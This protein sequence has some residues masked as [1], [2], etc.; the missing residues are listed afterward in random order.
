MLD[1]NKVIK[2]FKEE[3]DP[4]N[5]WQQ[6]LRTAFNA[7]RYIGEEY[8]YMKDNSCFGE[9]FLISLSDFSITTADNNDAQD[10]VKS[11]KALVVERGTIMQ[12]NKH[13]YRANQTSVTYL[14]RS[15]ITFLTGCSGHLE[16]D[17]VQSR[18]SQTIV[19][20]HHIKQIGESGFVKI[21]IFRQTKLQV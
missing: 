6:D 4:D 19:G 2:I 1:I 13:F 3:E 16:E 18:Y 7:L 21:T 10:K 20:R 8:I 11:L 14:Q 15:L 12:K 9:D 5:N 17:T